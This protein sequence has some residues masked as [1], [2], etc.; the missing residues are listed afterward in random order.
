MNPELERLKIERAVDGDDDFAVEHASV[1]QLRG[2]RFDQLWKVAVER[3][4]I[5]ALNEHV[6]AVAKDQRAKAVPFWF[7]NPSSAGG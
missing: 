3:F 6:E 7:E 1:G 4:L 5:A 2:Q